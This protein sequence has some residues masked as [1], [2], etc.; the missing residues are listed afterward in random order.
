[1]S[2]AIEYTDPALIEAALSQY[3]RPSYSTK[4]NVITIP[5]VNPN[6]VSAENK[7]LAASLALTTTVCQYLEKFLTSNNQKRKIAVI[8]KKIV[9]LQKRIAARITDQDIFFIGSRIDKMNTQIGFDDQPSYLVYLSFAIAILT[10][11]F[12]ELSKTYLTDHHRDLDD[13]QNRLSDL[14]AYLS[15][16]EK[17]ETKA[18]DA[19]A[20]DLYKHWAGLF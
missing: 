5:T 10:D 20:T 19:R 11:S 13:I 16:K 17:A 7:R 8:K 3:H 6:N 12:P 4:S 18:H 14:H 1:M 15:K 2:A 9:P